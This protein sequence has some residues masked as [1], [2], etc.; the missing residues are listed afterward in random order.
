[1]GR[2]KLVNA[3]SGEPM[4]AEF[5]TEAVLFGADG[6][7]LGSCAERSNSSGDGKVYLHHL[8]VLTGGKMAPYSGRLTVTV[9][10]TKAVLEFTETP[11]DFGTVYVRPWVS[12]QGTG[13]GRLVWGRGHGVE[14]SF[15][16]RA[17]LH[18]LNG[19]VVARCEETVKTDD[20]GRFWITRLPSV[21]NAP[22]ARLRGRMEVR[23][24]DG[25]VVQ[26]PF[27][28]VPVEWG[29]VNVCPDCR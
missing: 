5:R 26:R 8:P 11:A 22:S 21:N 24:P 3:V 10:Q 2:V 4:E 25:P 19:Q 29:D 16:V 12:C 7:A 9:Q 15:N 20:E 17:S 14:T 28:R 13:K 27:E 18:D 1:M 6:E 23:I